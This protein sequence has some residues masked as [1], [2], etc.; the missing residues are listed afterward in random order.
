MF[1]KI[2]KGSDFRGCVNYVTRAKKDN[3]D[4]S[5]CD[6]W[7]LIASGD[8]GGEENREDIIRSFED[9]QSLNPRV[10]NA[11]GHISLNFASEDK[12]RLDDDTMVEI[13]GKYMERMGITDTPYIIVR[14]YDKEHP[15]CHIVFSRVN[16]KGGTI[17]D[18][19]DYA[20]NKYVCRDLTDEYGLKVS[21]GKGK[22]NVNRLRGS[23]KLPY[24]I[25][26][27]VDSA[28]NNPGIDSWDRFEKWLKAG[29]VDIE[30]KCRKGTTV[31]EGISF[32]Y[33]GRK[34]S[35]SKIDRRFSFGNLD[36]HFAGLQKVSR[37]VEVQSAHRKVHQTQQPAVTIAT[38]AVNTSPVEE[39]G[40]SCGGDGMTWPEFRAMHPDLPVREALRRF[41]AK[42][43]G[44]NL[45]G[46]FS[47]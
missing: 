31:R 30:Y 8:M 3:P 15:H 17:S 34:F 10:R 27:I 25:F 47:I 19:N 9:N 20:R 29:G 18:K 32:I 28:W 38:P 5:P 6:E 36:R 2:R 16:S 14:H 45:N 12:D 39:Q 40:W 24:Q 33:K 41:R 11:V 37:K 26:H 13:A 43:R 46:G 1:A 7:R 23:D 42:K 21:E 22:T 35:G 44:A 4:G